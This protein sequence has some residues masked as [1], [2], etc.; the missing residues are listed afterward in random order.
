MGSLAVGSLGNK[1]VK[2]FTS[3]SLPRI[4]QS[5]CVYVHEA[6]TSRIGAMYIRY[7][8]VGAYQVGGAPP[9]CSKELLPVGAPTVTLLNTGITRPLFFDSI[10]VYVTT[11]SLAIFC[12]FVTPAAAQRQ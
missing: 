1:V 12:F 5:A 4:T 7:E 10:G 9:T 2:R 11:V 8:R 3:R 6:K